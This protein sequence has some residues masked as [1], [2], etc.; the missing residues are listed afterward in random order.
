M[1]PALSIHLREVDRRGGEERCEP[2]ARGELDAHTRPAEH[3]R[4]TARLREP[5]RH[6]SEHERNADLHP[7]KEERVIVGVPVAH[8]PDVPA[9]VESVRE[10]T[11]QELRDER[12]QDERD[13][14]EP[15][16]PVH[17][18]SLPNG[19]DIVRWVFRCG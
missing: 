4:E 3:R 11:A 15:P 10:A 1:R 17:I 9:D 8:R 16:L 6:A 18:G 12:E 2:Q 5:P 14:G 7:G 13:P 19:A